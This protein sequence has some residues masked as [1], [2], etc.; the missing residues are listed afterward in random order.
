MNRNR[1]SK[2]ISCCQCGGQEERGEGGMTRRSTVGFE[3]NENTLNGAM[4]VG[5]RHY[6][7][8]QTHIMYNTRIE[9]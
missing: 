1:G 7:F 4:M 3:G 8:V 6:T 2:N 5:I 9:P